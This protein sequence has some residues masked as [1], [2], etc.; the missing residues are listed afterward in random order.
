MVAA[1]QSFG[2][3]LRWNPHLH[4]IVL[5]DGFDNDG[6]FFYIPFSGL[7]SMVEVFRRR[8]VTL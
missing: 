7:D 3:M 6:T 4:A 8:V 2:D 1:H 5:E